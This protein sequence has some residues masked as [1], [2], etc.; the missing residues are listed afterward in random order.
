MKM[1]VETPREYILPNVVALAI[2]RNLAFVKPNALC[3]SFFSNHTHGHISLPQS[4]IGL[5]RTS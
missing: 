2:L 1:H 3:L 5:T 4:L